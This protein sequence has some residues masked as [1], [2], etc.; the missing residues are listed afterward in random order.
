MMIK[1]SPASWCAICDWCLQTKSIEG[2]PVDDGFTSAVERIGWEYHFPD[3]AREGA[4]L[5]PE[6]RLAKECR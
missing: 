4:L 3:D 1:P 5:C 2:L 6:C